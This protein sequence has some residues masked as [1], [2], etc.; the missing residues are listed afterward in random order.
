MRTPD[1]RTILKRIDQIADLKEGKL[2]YEP[3]FEEIE[4]LRDDTSCQEEDHIVMIDLLESI[5]QGLV[6][7]HEKPTKSP[8]TRLDTQSLEDDI[9]ALT[10]AVRDATA[11]FEARM[12]YV[13]QKLEAIEQT[14][15][16]RKKKW[17]HIF[18]RH[19][20]THST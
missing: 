18:R 5:E 12:I 20:R 7:L 4:L 8:V 14:Q 6:A 9:V 10:N 17:Y 16:E 19:E 3:I 15:Q 11:A 13:M 1:I 2:N